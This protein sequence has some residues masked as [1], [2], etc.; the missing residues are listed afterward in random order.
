MNLAAQLERLHARAVLLGTGD[1]PALSPVTL[2]A[3]AG[4]TLDAWQRT[5]LT[6]T[7]HQIILLVT[8]QGG[9]ST[10]SAIR[11]LH[12]ALYT[13]ASLVLLLAPSY[14]QSKEL[15]RKVKDALAALPFSVALASESALELE[16]T[17]LSR[18]VALPG[19]EA[20][21]RGFSGV[22]LLI[23]D[24]ASRVPD[25]LY[26]AVRPMLA[27]SGGDILLLSTPFGKRGFFHHEWT[28][29]GAD[30]H[31]TKVTAE[32]CPRIPRNWLEQERQSIGS[33]W[34]EQ[35]YLCKFVESVDSVFRYEDIQRALDPKV[36]PLFGAHT[37]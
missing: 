8:R 11:A 17:N 22:S 30:W 15:F 5:V 7:A 18:I 16:F 31:R 19:K 28:E 2:A 35:E 27:V 1:V 13:P 29:G 20:T 21:I 14:R 25:E 10:V 6:S 34:F 24:E 9:K 32:D 3:P 4:F 37:L 33:F 36:T 12:R 23:V 26:Q